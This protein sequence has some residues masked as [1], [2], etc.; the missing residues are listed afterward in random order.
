ML[1]CVCACVY[2]YVLDTWTPGV[3]DIYV[4]GRSLVVGMYQC[5]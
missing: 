5:M 4:A 3:L 2:A 1:S